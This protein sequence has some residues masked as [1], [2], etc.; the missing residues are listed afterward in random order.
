[1]MAKKRRAQTRIKLDDIKGFF[2]EFG[3]E[4][5][6]AAAILGAT[7]LDECLRELIANFLVDD[8]TEVDKLLGGPLQFFGSR[9]RASY[10]MGLIS[11]DEYHDL[12]IIRDVRNDFAHDLHGLSFSTPSVIKQ[13]S[14]LQLPR[15][16]PRWPY[17]TAGGRDPFMVSVA[18]L[19]F[20]LKLR[21]LKQKRQRRVIPSGF[22]VV[23][24]VD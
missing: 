13:C 17:A 12:K 11:E 1:M 22:E 24:T 21:I 3:D 14:A 16:A 20:Q 19:S 9:V 10:C 8:S 4:S 6:R 15:K 18:L 2:R 5:D 7:Y 23:E